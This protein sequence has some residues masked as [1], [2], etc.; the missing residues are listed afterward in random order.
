[1][2]GASHGPADVRPGKGVRIDEQHLPARSELQRR[3]EGGMNRDLRPAGAQPA[4]VD[5]RHGDAAR[6]GPGQAAAGTTMA[7]AADRRLARDAIDHEA[8]ATL[9]ADH[10]C[11]RPRPKRTVDGAYRE[12]T[13]RKQVLHGGDIPTSHPATNQT[14]AE[15]MASEATQRPQRPATWHA[16][17]NEPLAPLKAPH[18][19]PRL[20]SEDPVDCSAMDPLNAE[21]D[22]ERRDVRRPRPSRRRHDEHGGADDHEDAVSLSE[23]AAAGRS[24]AEAAS[25][26]ERR[27]PRARPA[28]QWPAFRPSVSRT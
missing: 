9:V 2:D 20:R 13:A 6:N 10:G 24:C 26:P 19:G 3:G 14:A 17:D 27:S 16:V 1:M 5:S 7:E 25:H 22:L 18:C 8:R 12:S 28:A 23:T 4:D 21:G 15:A 11:L